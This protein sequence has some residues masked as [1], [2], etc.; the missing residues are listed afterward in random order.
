MEAMFHDRALA[1]AGLQHRRNLIPHPVQHAVEVDVDDAMPVVQV[2]ISGGRL[3]AAD[4]GVVHRVV[5][6]SV[7]LY[8]VA[9]HCLTVL[10]FGRVLQEGTG[11]ASGFLDF[12]RD[13]LGG[14]TLDVGHDDL[15]SPCSERLANRLAQP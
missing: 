15:G 14:T 13:P 4:S 2:G 6:S 10:R 1:R 5:Q 3:C 12:G 9:H 11:G 8:G 7:R